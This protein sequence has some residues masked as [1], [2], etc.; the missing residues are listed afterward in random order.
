MRYYTSHIIVLVL[1]FTALLTSCSDDSPSPA[2]DYHQLKNHAVTNTA[3]T[4]A[5]FSAS[6][7]HTGP[8]PI[9]EHGFTWGKTKPFADQKVF[10]LV[11]LGSRSNDTGTF[12]A[13]VDDYQF[14]KKATYYVRPFVRTAN[15]MV[16]G[17]MVTF[18]PHR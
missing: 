9:L 16:Y 17:D 8:E 18:I 13:T 15:T 6:I 14:E 5:T 10:G 3:A 2:R 11:E 4:R 7:I 12:T 1:L